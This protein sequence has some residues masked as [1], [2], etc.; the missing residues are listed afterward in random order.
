MIEINHDIN[1]KFEF[2]NEE[3]SDL[4]KQILSEEEIKDFLSEKLVYLLKIFFIIQKN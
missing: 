1:A 3:F 4:N 2:L